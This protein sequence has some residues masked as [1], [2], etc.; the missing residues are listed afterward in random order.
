M[1]GESRAAPAGA[2][3]SRP[4]GAATGRPRAAGAVAGRPPARRYR[5]AA[6]ALWKAASQTPALPASR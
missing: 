2:V 1:R 3:A 5:G 6:I 4:P